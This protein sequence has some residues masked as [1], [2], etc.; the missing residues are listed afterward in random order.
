VSKPLV[1][2]LGAHAGDDTAFYIERGFQVISLEAH[3]RLART[4]EA[5]F[6]SSLQDVRVVNK[7]ISPEGAPAHLFVSNKGEAGETHSIYPHRVKGCEKVGYTVPG[8]TI[9]RLFAAHGVPHYMKVDLEGADVLAIRQ[10]HEWRGAENVR[11]DH[12][13][14]PAYLSVELDFDHPEEALEIFSHLAYMG[15]EGFEL[16]QQFDPAAL[17][18]PWDKPVVRETFLPEDCLYQAD[19]NAAVRWWFE[20]MLLRKC[21]PFQPQWYDLHARHSG[22]ALQ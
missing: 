12:R 19:L 21:G 9:G 5:R 15:Y 13:P 6:R 7:A 3:P 17:K 1:Y 20:K 11:H 2:D 14:V 16:V 8:T 4:L 22:G 10:L 18:A